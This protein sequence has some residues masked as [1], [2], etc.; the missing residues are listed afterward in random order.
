MKHL[1]TCSLNPSSATQA[2]WRELKQ[3]LYV[4]LRSLI[5]ENKV[6]YNT[7][8]KYNNKGKG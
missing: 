8:V 6:K 3:N 7:K 1:S 2:D 5:N 4:E